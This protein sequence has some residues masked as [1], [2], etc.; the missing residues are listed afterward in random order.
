MAILGRQPASVF[1]SVLRFLTLIYRRIEAINAV[2]SIL[3]IR[4]L[5]V[6]IL[7][8]VLAKAR[9]HIVYGPFSF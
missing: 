7:P 2:Y 8:P 1:P 9:K 3:R 5:R 4:R 6:R